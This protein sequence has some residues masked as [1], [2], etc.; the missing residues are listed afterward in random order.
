MERLAELNADKKVHGIL[1]QLP[2]PEHLD[3][4]KVMDAIDMRKDADGLTAE[5]LGALARQGEP[6]S[7]PCTPAGLYGAAE[8]L[9]GGAGGQGLRA[10]A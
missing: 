2:L 3:E 7:V 5:N 10:S 9:Q 6:L 8:A 4:R 1:V